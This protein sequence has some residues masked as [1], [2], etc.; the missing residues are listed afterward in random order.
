MRSVMDSMAADNEDLWKGVFQVHRAGNGDG[1]SIR[2]C[3][4]DK[5]NIDSNKNRNSTGNRKSKSKSKRG[6]SNDSKQI[7]INSI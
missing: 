6:S 1:V 4:I 5:S 7:V 3:R 2:S